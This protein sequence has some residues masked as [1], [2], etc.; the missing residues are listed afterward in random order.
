M[1]AIQMKIIQIEC[2]QTICIRIKSLWMKKKHTNE[3]IRMENVSK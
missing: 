2:T 3:N 1:K